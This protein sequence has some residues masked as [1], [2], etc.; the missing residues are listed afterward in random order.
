MYD[1]I[2][3]EVIVIL[4]IGLLMPTVVG[5][6]AQP[7]NIYEKSKPLNVNFMDRNK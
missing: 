2:V 3:S 5:M 7:S 6:F 4:G 1:G